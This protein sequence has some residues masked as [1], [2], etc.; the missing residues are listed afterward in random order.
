MARSFTIRLRA[1]LWRWH[2]RIGLWC[3]LVFLMLS[4]TGVLLNHTSEMS[5]S[6]RQ[7]SS[8]LLLTHYGFKTPKIYSFK[9][10]EHWLSDVG[11]HQVYLND[12][13][14]Q[15]CSGSLVGVV[16]QEQFYVAACEEEL[17]LLMPDGELIERIA[18]VYS[19]PTPISALGSCDQGLCLQVGF[20]IYS[21][22]IEQFS[23]TKIPPQDVSW[24]VSST[25]PVD[26]TDTLKS[27]ALGP[28]LTMERVLLDLH[29]GR[30]F[31]NVG[32]W[33][34]DLAALGL[35]LL[36]LSGFWMWYQQMKRRS[37]M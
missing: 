33:I 10:G 13:P 9:M 24:S 15:D 12:Q 21:A 30:I 19:L 11:A 6:Q 18:S 27:K 28:G 1:F 23:W 2:K 3:M 37:S 5:L 8:E 32:V 16:E 34:V 36:M 14:L 7:I 35:V 4:V 29:S 22:D 17:L 26:V 25:P 20:D 31:G